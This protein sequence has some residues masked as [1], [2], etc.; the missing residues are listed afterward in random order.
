MSC[1]ESATTRNTDE[2]RVTTTIAIDGSGRA[3]VQTG[4][5]MLDHLL[6]QIARHGLFDIAIAA[7]GDDQHHIVEDVAICLGRTL[8]QA[9]GEK[10]GIVRMGHALVP[11]D[12]A[13]ASVAIDLSG[14]PGAYLSL[15]FSSAFI[16]DLEADMVRHFLST[17]AT[18]GRLTLHAKIQ[19]GLNDHHKAEAVFKALA[20]ALDDAC[21]IDPRRAGDVPSSKGLLEH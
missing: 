5:R 16:G 14:R 20:R 9:L 18:E 6:T 4:V 15:P 21:A 8:N 1:R 19:S 12:E 7:G 3:D 2:T 17:F 11:M 10:R 13:L